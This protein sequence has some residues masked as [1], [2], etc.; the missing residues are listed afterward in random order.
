MV[1]HG[2]TNREVKG[3]AQVIAAV[4]A[5]R[6]EGV[7]VRLDLIEGVTATRRWRASRA[8]DVIVDQLRLGWY[9]GL[10]VEGMALG[11]P[12]LAASA[13]TTADNPF[14]AAL[15]VVRSRPADAA[16]RTCVSCSATASGAAAR[17]ARAARSSSAI[18]TRARW[19]GRSSTLGYGDA[20]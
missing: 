4:D 6:A 2:P 12:V 10:A 11:R 8:A 9:G 18:T 7:P 5:L 15:P 17:R 1:A 14:G 19:P 3:T 16:R 13:R 20:P